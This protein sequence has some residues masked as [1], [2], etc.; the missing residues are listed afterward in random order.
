VPLPWIARRANLLVEGLSLPVA[1]GAIIQVGAVRLEVTAETWPCRRR[2]QTHPGLLTALARDARG[3][4]TCRVV[5]GGI[6]RNGDEVVVV[7]RPPA[8]R[9]RLPG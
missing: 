7:L 5:D 4:V 1:R 9:P 6:V 3:G 2:E 8:H